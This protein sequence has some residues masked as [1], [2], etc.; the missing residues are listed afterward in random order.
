VSG[1]EAVGSASRRLTSLDEARGIV[2]AEVRPLEAETVDLSRSLGR[3]L[4][5]P[6][7]ATEAVPPFDNSAMDGFAVRAADT[8]GASAARPAELRLVGESRAG[9][10]FY[11]GLGPGEAVAIS[12]G[13]AVPSGADAI[14]PLEEAQQH[15]GA[16]EVGLETVSG[17]FMRRRGDDISADQPVLAAGTSIGPSELGVLGSLGITQVACARRPR[18][19]LVI[20]GDEL[21]EPGAR[22]GPGQIHDSNGLTLTA[23]VDRAG[24]ELVANERVPDD[25]D[26]IRGAARSALQADVAVIS[27]GVSVGEHDHVGQALAELGVASLFWGVAVRPGRPTW[28]GV[29]PSRTLVFGLPG[30]PVSAMVCFDLLVRPA[31]LAMQG[32]SPDRHR[33]RAILASDYPKEPGR[34]HAVRCTLE[35]RD[36]GWHARPTRPEQASHILTSMLGAE[37]L[38]LIP[39]ESGDVRAGTWVEIELVS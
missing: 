20:S 33:A 36:G 8:A 15:D 3:V 23:L 14:V 6:V 21:A 25:L 16:V 30:N 4:A 34:A 17:R 13:A 1:D 29:A 5:G 10:P 2:L 37:A 28:F 22:L 27:G 18:T 39:A 38:A 31:L 24:G 32:A 11:T 12:T 7:A 26:E 9:R 19:A 35:L